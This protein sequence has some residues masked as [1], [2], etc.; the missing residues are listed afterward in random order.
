MA[1]CVY[2]ADEPQSWGQRVF[3]TP[4]YFKNSN[5]IYRFQWGG[6]ETETGIRNYEIGNGLSN[7]NALIAMNLQSTDGTPTV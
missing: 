6:Y 5:G 7:T 4:S 1:K 3:T 2:V